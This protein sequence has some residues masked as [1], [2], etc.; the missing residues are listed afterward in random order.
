MGNL[1]PK[2]HPLTFI[3][4]NRRVSLFKTM[5][6]FKSLAPESKSKSK[7]TNLLAWISIM[8]LAISCTLA[9]AQTPTAKPPAPVLRPELIKSLQASQDALKA[10]Q[11]EQAFELAQQAMAIPNISKDEKPV[12]LRIL[13]ASALQAKKFDVAISS[14]ETLIQDLSENNDQKMSYIETLLSAS[15]QAKELDKFVKWARIYLDM[16]GRNPSVRPVYF[17]TLSVLNRHEEA[18]KEVQLKMKLDEAAKVITPENEI[19][20]MAFSQR[21]LK[22]DAAYYATLKLLL[23]TYPKKAYWAEVIPRLARQATFNARFDLDLYR[24]LEQTGNIEDTNEYADM[25]N[26]SLNLGL[27]AEAARVVEAAYSAGIFGKGSDAANHQK[28]RQQIQQKLNEDEKVLPALEKSAKD[29]NS[30]ASLADV[31]AS[32]Q[33]WDLAVAS[34]TKAFEIGALRREAETRLHAGIALSKAGKKAEAEKMW[35]SVKGDPT[36]V[37]LAQLWKLWQKAN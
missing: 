9:S 5:T 28:L 16:G 36:A 14:L 25:A 22:D 26:L 30:I 11:L 18:V 20:L 13:L 2:L 8:M 29:A 19:R 37:E 12:V 7:S 4:V 27:P 34:Y 6:C 3:V 21:V 35:D 10:G 23:Q 15:Q 31:Y 33:K 1:V 17:Q 24:L 32:K